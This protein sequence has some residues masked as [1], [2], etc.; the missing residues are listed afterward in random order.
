MVECRGHSPQWSDT[1]YDCI[2]NWNVGLYILLQNNG[3]VT[4]SVARFVQKE[5]RRTDQ[6]S[7]RYKK[8][9]T[10]LGTLQK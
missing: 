9:V 10:T 4:L 6:F 7:K 1:S 5:L 8:L 3:N 2:I